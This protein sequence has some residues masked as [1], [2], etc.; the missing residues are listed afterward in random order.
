MWRKQIAPLSEQFTVLT[1]DLPGFG[2]TPGRF[3]VDAS[4]AAIARLAA[5]RGSPVHICGFS[6]GAMVGLRFAAEHPDQVDRLVLSAPALVPA[7]ERRAVW[8]YR[9]VPGPIMMRFADMPDHAGWLAMV[10]ELVGVDLRPFL[11]RISARTLVLCG[12]RDRTNLADARTTA[13]SIADARLIVV[14]HVGH[15]WP[16]YAPKAFNAIVSGFLAG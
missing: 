3:T 5:E 11:P 12:S 4:V 16:I 15:T 1:P 9:H 10:D 14:P 6:L 7:V 2:A 8:F 13:A